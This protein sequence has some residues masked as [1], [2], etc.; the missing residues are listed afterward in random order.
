MHEGEPKYTCIPE[1]RTKWT[2]RYRALITSSHLGRGMSQIRMLSLP[3]IKSKPIIK[4]KINLWVERK[5]YV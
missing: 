2:S 4:I 3:D 5:D 1:R